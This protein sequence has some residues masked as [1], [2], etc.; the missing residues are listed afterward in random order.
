MFVNIRLT[1]LK[2]RKIQ[3]KLLAMGIIIYALY[4]A[5]N[6]V[7]VNFMQYNNINCLTTPIMYSTAVIHLTERHVIPS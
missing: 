1:T 3:M 7:T 5:T 2:E 4:L 6:I